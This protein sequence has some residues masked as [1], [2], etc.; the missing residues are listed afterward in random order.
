MPE[1]IPTQENFITFWSERAAEHNRPNQMMDNATCY[2]RAIM[3][4]YLEHLPISDPHLT[5]DPLKDS[6]IK[7]CLEEMAFMVSPYHLLE[8]YFPLSSSS[9]YSMSNGRE[10]WCWGLCSRMGGRT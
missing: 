1:L 4:S 10:G 3:T 7:F 2:F 6:W 8:K 9:V 5:G